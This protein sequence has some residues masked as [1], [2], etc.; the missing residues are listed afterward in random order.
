MLDSKQYN[1]WLNEDIAGGAQTS[2]KIGTSAAAELSDLWQP[3]E[4]TQ[5]DWQQS[6]EQRLCQ[7]GIVTT[8][9]IEQAR[10]IHQKSPRKR[11]GQIL[12][13]M[14]VISEADLMACLAEQYDLP[15][16]RLNREMIDEKA[17]S[18]LDK[19]FIEANHV[20]PYSF[21]G[22]KLV[23]GTTDPTNVFLLDEVGRKTRR[24]IVVTVCPREDIKAILDAFSENATDYHVD[25]IIK[26]IEDDDVEVL[27][28][29][30][31]D[32]SDLER[33]AG[34]S[35]I[36]KFVNYVISNAVKEGA[37]DIHIEPGDKKLKLRYRIDGIL[38]EV[39]A[40]PH[41]MHAPVVSRIK[42]MSNLDIAE[43]RLPQDGRMRVAIHGRNVD[44]RVSTLPTSYGEKVVVRILDTGSAKL[45][46]EDL[47][48]GGETLAILKNQISRPHGI[49]LVT[50]PTGSGKSTT[51]YGA[52]RTM[53]FQR[54]NISTVE[55]PVE[56]QLDGIS[57]VQVHDRIGMS[58]AAALRSLLRQDPDVIMV[59]E[60]RDEETARIAV[61]ASLTGH[62]VLSTLHTN[63]APSSI[64]RL[65]NIGIEPY[66]IAASTNAV[67]A[68]RLVRR[69]CKHCKTTYQPQADEAAFIEMYGFSADNLFRGEGCEQCRHTGFQG[70]IGLY[71]LLVVDDT[72]R[73]IITN[74]PGV[75]EL[76]RLCK[77]RG[78][79]TLREDGFNKVHSGLTTID[80]VMRVT[81]ST[82]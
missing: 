50:G 35:P 58:F 63:D 24:Q 61:Q 70:R 79:V 30:E 31:E 78:M 52:L 65:I 51:L 13:E 2:E 64:T 5:D 73:D 45:S 7:R 3:G 82:V 53:D 17:L 18:L 6:I 32:I 39:M 59:G 9:Q 20:I 67:L 15:F 71:E 54:L 44:M 25:D 68:Q 19:S 28:T 36:I 74:N 33:V 27:D 46:L 21:E 66:L 42:I 43:R 69:A 12:L 38:F 62:L 55:D 81:E 75:S 14:G 40:P 16:V 72:Y 4:N 47:G 37:S 8:E 76:R 60:I 57:Q 23:V 56:Y 22:D 48:M 11:L 77:E 34:E 1:Q 49:I 26:N 80:E 10:S 29:Q 41:N